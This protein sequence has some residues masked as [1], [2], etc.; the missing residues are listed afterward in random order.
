VTLQGHIPG[1][2]LFASGLSG[3]GKHWSHSAEIL[4]SIYATLNSIYH[5]LYILLLGCI[6]LHAFQHNLQLKLWGIALP[7]IAHVTDYLSLFL[8]LL[9]QVVDKRE[10]YNMA[11]TYVALARRYAYCDGFPYY[12]KSA[13]I[14]AEGRTPLT[15]GRA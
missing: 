15:G 11:H 3:H 2:S 13:T 10:K 5:I 8:C 6:T 12:Y 4:F 14:E 7:W 1:L 9:Y